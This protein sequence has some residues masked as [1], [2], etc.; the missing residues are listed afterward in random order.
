MRGIRDANHFGILIPI[1]IMNILIIGPSW[2]GDSVMAQSLYVKLKK[3]PDCDIDVVSPPWTVP[4]MER[5][6]QVSKILCL[7]FYTLI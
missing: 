3:D 1:K 2:V 4:I 5:M 6:P 7:L